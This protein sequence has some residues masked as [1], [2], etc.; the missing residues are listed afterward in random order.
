[1]LPRT[2]RSTLVST[3]QPHPQVPAWARRDVRPRAPDTAH[4]TAVERASS[5]C[6]RSDAPARDSQH[7][8]RAGLR[9][10]DI[11]AVVRERVRA[12]VQSCPAPFGDPSSRSGPTTAALP[13]PTLRVDALSRHTERRS[14]T[15]TSN[16]GRRDEA[17]ACRTILTGMS[18]R[19]QRCSREALSGVRRDGN[20]AWATTSVGW[21]IRRTRC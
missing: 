13:S 4:H 19:V 10:D 3:A 21:G 20:E 11:A 15:T 17:I 8:P 7:S 5:M 14:R 18:L 6:R 9:R 1:M 12:S 2:L 16:D